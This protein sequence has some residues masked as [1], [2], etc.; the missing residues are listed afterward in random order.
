MHNFER[1]ISKTNAEHLIT[2]YL[3]SVEEIGNSLGDHKVL[4][5]LK[6]LKREALGAGPYPHVMMFEA[7]NRILSDLVILYGGS[8]C[9]IITSSHLRVIRLSTEMKTRMGSTSA[10]LGMEEP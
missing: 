4:H 5:L 6:V 9:W 7:A 8:G 1:T 2:T 10:P 3:A